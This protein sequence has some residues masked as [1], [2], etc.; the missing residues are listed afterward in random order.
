MSMGSRKFLKSI[1]VRHSL[2]K[3]EETK[4]IT[5][6]KPRARVL[7]R[8]VHMPQRLCQVNT[9]L[10]FSSRLICWRL[11]LRL[12]LQEKFPWNGFVLLALLYADTFSGLPVAFA[13]RWFWFFHK[14]R[15]IMV[16]FNFCRFRGKTRFDKS[17]H[18]HAT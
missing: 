8:D 14:F 16:L 2:P 6:N 4:W 18:Q 7:C 12:S 9:Y 15:N 11:I 3:F 13:Q 5:K 10:K 1:I 17:N